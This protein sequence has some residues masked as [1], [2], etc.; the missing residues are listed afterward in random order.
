MECCDCKKS[1]LEQDPEP[2]PV[3]IIT[4]KKPRK[5]IL[6][7]S[8]DGGGIRSIFQVQILLRI[9]EEFNIC[10][11][12]LF[13]MVVGTSM[14]GAVCLTLSNNCKKGVKSCLS[15]FLDDKVLCRFGNKS[16]WDKVMDK[17]QFEPLY[18]GNGKREIFKR[19]YGGAKFGEMSIPTVIT[20]YDMKRCEPRFFQSWKESEKDI[21]VSTI[22]DITTSAPVYFPPIKFEDSWF[23]DGGV[24]MSNPSVVA[25]TYAKEYFSERKSKNKTENCDHSEKL[26]IRIL[27]IGTGIYR[28]HWNSHELNKWGAPQWLQHGLL[29]LAFSAPTQAVDML[30]KE[31]LDDKL[32][33]LNSYEIGNIKMDDCEKDTVDTLIK[34]ADIIFNTKKELIR[35]FIKF[36]FNK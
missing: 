35:E 36:K 19:Q 15:N 34:T 12:S 33:R 31:L 24:A 11:C 23:V 21:L 20:A 3:D 5:P 26:D 17:L 6:V 27:S 4:C 25:Y 2:I 16:W 7:L 32:L 1:K 9:S 30:T 13:D 28:E 14:G 29:E 10:L 8:L 22:A 18:S